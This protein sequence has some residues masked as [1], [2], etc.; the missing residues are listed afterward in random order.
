M[1]TEERA[2]SNC[3]KAWSTEQSSSYWKSGTLYGERTGTSMS[4]VG[5]D[6]VSYNTVIRTGLGWARSD[7]GW[8]KS[9]EFS[10]SGSYLQ[11]T[12]IWM[13]S[14]VSSRS[15]K[16]EL[17]GA[18]ALSVL[19]SEGVEL[20]RRTSTAGPVCQAFM[21]YKK[22]EFSTVRDLEGRLGW[23]PHCWN[24]RASISGLTHNM[25]RSEKQVS[26]FGRFQL[27]PKGKG[28]HS[29]DRSGIRDDKHSPQPEKP[30]SAASPPPARSHTTLQVWQLGSTPGQA[31]GLTMGQPVFNGSKADSF[32]TKSSVTQRGF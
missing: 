26:T 6:P 18:W 21:W 12:V 24:E 8:T 16:M 30:H 27:H 23:S 32:P 2:V 4:P 19:H 25:S 5:S 20:W 7:W 15:T 14:T 9:E 28:N 13:Q 3:H 10:T 17:F 11:L 31:L 29:A 22:P 1:K